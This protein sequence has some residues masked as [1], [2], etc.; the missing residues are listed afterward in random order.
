[1]KPSPQTAPEN[2]AIIFAPHIEYPTR[3]GGDIYVDRFGC[4]LSKHM[5]PVKI[6]GAKTITTY[7]NSKIVEQQVYPNQPR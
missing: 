2:H 5:R 3:N 6:V 4:Y 1:M 7:K